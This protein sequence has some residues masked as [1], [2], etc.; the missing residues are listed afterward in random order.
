MVRYPLRRGDPPV[1]TAIDPV[2]DQEL[3]A[4]LHAGLFFTAGGCHASDRIELEGPRYL[5]QALRIRS[6]SSPGHRYAYA[7]LVI[8][9]APHAR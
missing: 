3:E 1:L 4:P 9:L 2:V 6:H 8:E 7:A 5:P